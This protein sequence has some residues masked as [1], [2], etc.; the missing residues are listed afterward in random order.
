MAAMMR[1]PE[2]D[3]TTAALLRPML[4]TSRAFYFLIIAL[5]IPAGWFVYAWYL[6]LIQGL[7]LTSMRTPVGAPWGAYIANF[8]FFVGLA[9]GGIAIAAAIRLLNL[10]KYT[11]VA[12]IGEVLT[13]ISLMM[14][15]LSIT[16][17]MGRP[18]RIF[19]IVI[20]WPQRVGTSSLSW[21]VTVII[22]YFT[23]SSVYL[24]LT[25]RKDLVLCA[26]RFPK[27]SWFYKIFLV[28]YKPDEEHK[29]ERMSWWLSIAIV[30][31]IV[32]LS[33]GVVP[34][35]FGLLPSQPGWFSALA[36]PYFLTAAIGS[37]IAAVIVVSGVLRKLF[38]WQEYIKP[39]I[40][41]GLGTFLGIITLFYIYLI[42]AEQ[43]TMRYAA[44]M[45]EFL[46]SEKLFQGEFAPIFWP[47]LLLGFFTPAIILVS[48]A[49]HPQWFGT[50]RTILAAGVIVAAFWVKRFLIVVPSLL[51]PLLP[52][53]EGSYS[54]SWLEWSI[55]AGI[56]ASAILLYTLFLKVF[57]IVELG[58]E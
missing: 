32:M 9:H 15:G 47:M 55:V 45:S 57:P 37:A 24:W 29:I 56:L 44:P 31:L 7:G 27:L 28:G 3:R 53:P 8:V 21:D 41:K 23:L 35:I 10:T 38:K 1:R 36:G 22:I 51:R 25:M 4:N 48:Q 42:L 6:Q 13:V 39:E 14:A 49:I 33:G 16:I 26:K 19:N 2:P 11:P 12:R 5:F 40:F 18:D 43:L 30:F 52:F 46:I 50:T 17:D 20:Y 34:W 58:E 54:P